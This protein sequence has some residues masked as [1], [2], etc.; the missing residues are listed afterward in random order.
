MFFKIFTVFLFIC[1][2]TV[3]SEKTIYVEPG[4]LDFSTYLVAPHEICN[5]ISCITVQKLFFVQDD[6]IVCPHGYLEIAYTDQAGKFRVASAK[7]DRARRSIKA[8]RLFENCDRLGT[9]PHYMSPTFSSLQK[10]TL[11]NQRQ[12]QQQHQQKHTTTQATTTTT[13]TIAN[14]PLDLSSILTDDDTFHTVNEQDFRTSI[15]Y[16]DIDYLKNKFPRNLFDDTG[17]AVYGSSLVAV[18]ISLIIALVQLNAKSNT[19]QI[20]AKSPKPNDYSSPIHSN[21]TQ[22]ANAPQSTV[23]SLRQDQIIQPFQERQASTPV[24]YSV[25]AQQTTTTSLPAA[26]IHPTN[27]SQASLGQANV[28]QVNEVEDYRSLAWCGCPV[29]KCI[30]GNCRCYRARRACGP[31]CHG[32]KNKFSNTVSTALHI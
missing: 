13:T 15:S 5:E 30:S 8:K 4:S 12:H 31:L 25:S 21:A 32:G 18:L 3:V 6:S 23:N 28:S 29:G 27:F 14:F 19:A 20:K 24:F 10:V 11:R 7:T 1:V 22:F 2:N 16:E 9:T 26:Q 17:D